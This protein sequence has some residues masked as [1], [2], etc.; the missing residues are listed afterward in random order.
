MNPC[1]C[2]TAANGNCEYHI[3]TGSCMARGDCE[4][5]SQCQRAD[6][7][8]SYGGVLCR[9]KVD[10][11]VNCRNST[12]ILAVNVGGALTIDR[13]GIVYVGDNEDVLVEDDFNTKMYRDVVKYFEGQDRFLFGTFAVGR[14]TGNEKGQCIYYPMRV[15]ENGSFELSIRTTEPDYLI[16]GK[17][18]SIIC[19][20]ND[21]RF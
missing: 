9:S 20:D 21:R 18:V 14:A 17:R 1:A 2:K 6:V 10:S 3:S 5:M 7:L 13:R 4:S 19:N 12:T 15:E 11:D 8:Y 16:N